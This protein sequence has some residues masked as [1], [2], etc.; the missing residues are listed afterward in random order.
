MKLEYLATGS[1][2]CPLLRIYGD[3]PEVCRRLCR[4]IEQLA[5]SAIAT[6]V[7]SNLPGI[8]PIDGCRLV[9]SAGKWD[10][11]V[12]PRGDN[13]FEW[14]LTPAT[15]DNVVSRI[16]S[17][18]SPGAGEYQWLND[19]GDLNVLISRTGLW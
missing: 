8:E 6:T 3:E 1:D 2:D 16:A 17:F 15:W 9:A 12:V 7:L 11:G 4:A 5:Q 14:I 18:C 19:D 10:R 13:H